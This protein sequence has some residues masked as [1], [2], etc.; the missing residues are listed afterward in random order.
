MESA[1]LKSIVHDNL[2]GARELAQRS[3]TLLQR[4]AAASAATRP[5]GLLDELADLGA[6]VARSKP[7]MPQVFQTIN[8][9]LLEA[10]AEE[11]AATDVGPFR[12]RLLALLGQHLR[13]LQT[14]LE[15]VADHAQPLLENG[16]V[17]YTVSRSSTVRAALRRAKHD[18]KL[19]DVIVPESRPNLEGRALARELSGDQIP[20]RLLVDA[21][22][23]TAIDGCDRL[24]VG[25]DAITRRGIVNK[26]GTRLAA[27]AARDR[28]VP[29]TVLAESSKAWVRPVE[30]N[31][32]LLT[33][34]LREPKEVWDAAP[35]GVEVVNLYFERTPLEL[36]TE[37]VDEHGVHRPAEYWDHVGRGGAAR[38]LARALGDASP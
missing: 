1:E 13:G 33:G 24:L 35:H 26:I 27:L 3:L 10:E 15:R 19:F 7:E 6:A 12:V 9:W 17:L 11:E 4:A 34:R 5:E 28:G 31:L 18:G 16:C 36:V 8:R 23:G 21:L 22:A 20:V 30:L 32:G 2:S 14:D 38:R 37:I 25:A 29:V